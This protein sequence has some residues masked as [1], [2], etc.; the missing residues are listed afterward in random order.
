LESLLHLQVQRAEAERAAM[1]EELLAAARREAAAAQAAKA[2]PRLQLQ[3][4][5]SLAHL[6]LRDM[7]AHHSRWLRRTGLSCVY[8]KVC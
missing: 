2:A 5:V 3:L 8:I 4:Q 6:G 7:M 1:L